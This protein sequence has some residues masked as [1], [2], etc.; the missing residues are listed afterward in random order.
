MNKCSINK[1]I[2]AGQRRNEEN[3][4]IPRNQR[5]SKMYALLLS[6]KFKRPGAERE[7][8][9]LQHGLSAGGFEL[10]GVTFDWT[11]RSGLE[12]VIGC[13]DSIIRG[14][15]LLFVCLMSHGGRG[16]LEPSR[17]QTIPV[18]DILLELDQKLPSTVPLASTFFKIK[19]K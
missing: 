6:S 3:Y 1:F 9:Y 19:V 16:L 15:S 12:H 2:L 14:C 17:G 5:N 7:A 11:G 10:A 8:T 18:N 4:I 13:V